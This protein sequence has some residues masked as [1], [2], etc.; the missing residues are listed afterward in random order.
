MNK[1]NQL[2]AYSNI[3]HQLTGDG[4]IID[5]TNTSHGRDLLEAC[6][7]L[8]KAISL[9]I[10]FEKLKGFGKIPLLDVFLNDKKH[11]LGALGLYG[12]SQSSMPSLEHDGHGQQHLIELDNV[13]KELVSDLLNVRKV[14][15]IILSSAK[16]LLNKASLTIGR[17][18]LSFSE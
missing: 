8:N 7:L 11:H 1:S 12:L 6:I 16:P 3:D 13:P 4:L 5:L 9:I 2:L 18:T 15:R 17:V 14:N 10:N